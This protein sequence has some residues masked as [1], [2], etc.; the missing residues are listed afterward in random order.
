MVHSRKQYTLIFAIEHKLWLYARPAPPPR[1]GVS[2][3]CPLFLLQEQQEKEQRK[4][5]LDQIMTAEARVRLSNIG[6]FQWCNFLPQMWYMWS[7]GVRKRIRDYV[8]Y[9]ARTHVEVRLQAYPY[10]AVC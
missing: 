2:S 5:I 8:L 7:C 1:S 4:Q 10:V 9:G 3:I 6:A